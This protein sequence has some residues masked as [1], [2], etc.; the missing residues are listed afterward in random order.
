[1]TIE[2]TEFDLVALARRGLQ[3][4]LDQA[5]SEIQYARKYATGDVATRAP[6]PESAEAM[7]AAFEAHRVAKERLDRF[8][9]LHPDPKW[10]WEAAIVYRDDRPDVV[11]TRPGGVT[12][13]EA[14]AVYQ[15]NAGVID[16]SEGVVGTFRV[17][18]PKT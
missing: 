3:A 17:R 12:Q 2:P 8:E 4:L 5:F 6:T 1:M 10:L 7:K 16:R 18:A 13:D 14:I 11:L 15:A 9:L